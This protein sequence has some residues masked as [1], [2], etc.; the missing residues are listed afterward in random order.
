MFF[1]AEYLFF[2]AG[3]LSAK[4]AATYTLAAA[5]CGCCPLLYG[6]THPMQA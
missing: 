1:R 4:A 2:R 3:R 5:E 6:L